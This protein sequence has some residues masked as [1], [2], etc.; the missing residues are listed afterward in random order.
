MSSNF[1][2]TEGRFGLDIGKKSFSVRVVRQWIR[3]PRE[4]VDGLSLEVFKVKIDGPLS[5][6]I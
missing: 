3:L 5:N 2:L 4:I 1:K 6:L